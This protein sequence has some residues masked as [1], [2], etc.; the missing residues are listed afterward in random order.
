MSSATIALREIPQ[1]YKKFSVKDAVS[2]VLKV[3]LKENS[4]TTKRE[5]HS[6]ALEREIALEISKTLL[7]TFSSEMIELCESYHCTK[8]TTQLKG[9]SKLTDGKVGTRPIFLS[10]Y[11][12]NLNGFEFNNKATYNKTFKANYH[13]KQGSRRDQVII[14]F[15][16]FVPDKSFNRSAEATNF[17][18]NARFVALSDFRYDP[19]EEKYCAMNGELHGK[20][21]SYN[22]GMLPIL[23]MPLDPKTSQ[24]CLDQKS[25]PENVALLL[26]MSVSFY[27]YDQGRFVHLSNDGCMQIKQVF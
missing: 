24:L 10:K 27:T 3:S 6:T 23:K 20:F 16:A 4:L 15:P 14:H 26:I 12:K 7:S 21:S 1:E 22:S 18:I 13:I 2:D 9:L 25:I 11:G 8:L 17:K 19:R 5:S